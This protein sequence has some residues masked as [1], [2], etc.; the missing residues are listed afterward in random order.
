[1]TT[2]KDQGPHGYCGTFARVAAAEGQ[3]GL[4]SGLPKKNFSV[5]RKN[6]TIIAQQLSSATCIYVRICVGMCAR[7]YACVGRCVHAYA[8]V[9]AAV[10]ARA[11]VRACVR[12]YVRACLR[13]CTCVCLSVCLSV[14]FN[15]I[16]GSS[17]MVTVGDVYCMS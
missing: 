1:M 11:V 6:I 8:C 9:H 4:H 12:V 15:G 14:C 7:A 17:D 10:Y 5:V 3:Y 13:A 16:T 2:A